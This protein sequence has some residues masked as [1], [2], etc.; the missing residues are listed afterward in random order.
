[1]NGRPNAVTMGSWTAISHTPYLKAVTLFAK[2]DCCSGGGLF[3]DNRRYWLDDGP[4]QHTL[5]WHCDSLERIAQGHDASRRYE[6]GN[7]YFHQLARDGWS[8]EVAALH[9]DSSVLQRFHKIVSER[10][11]LRKYAHSTLA[12]RLG[13]GSYFETHELVDRRSDQ[14]LP[15][16][17]WEWADVDRGRLVWAA[18]GLLGVTTIGHDN[19][20][21]ADRVLHDFNAMRFEHR[22]APY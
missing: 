19:S 15:R 18:Q 2:G 7:I 14:V 4:Y 3:I 22:M 12:R 5:R 1:M 13:R 6:W 9:D 21:G 8:P 16:D 11:L 20:L 10:W 17:D